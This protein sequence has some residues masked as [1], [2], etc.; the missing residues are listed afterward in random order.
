M[1]SITI[2]SSH[3]FP[4]GLLLMALDLFYDEMYGPVIY[5]NVRCSL[6]LENVTVILISST[7]VYCPTVKHIQC[8]RSEMVQQLFILCW[9]PGWIFQQTLPA[10]IG[11]WCVVKESHS[12]SAW[13]QRL[14]EYLINNLDLLRHVYGGFCFQSWKNSVQTHLQ[15]EAIFAN[16]SV[17]LWRLLRDNC[18]RLSLCELPS[19]LL[20]AFE[21]SHPSSSSRFCWPV[22][23]LNSPM[24]SNTTY[25]LNIRRIITQPE[26]I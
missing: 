25:R 7:V 10:D 17:P 24:R 5:L 8:L 3:C 6:K 12:G 19:S 16:K 4:A 9:K 20:S 2:P 11:C 21:P 15:S 26:H 1:F 22:H 23:C 14:W 13:G 18:K